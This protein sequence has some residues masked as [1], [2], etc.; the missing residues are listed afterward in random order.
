MLKWC[1]NRRTWLPKWSQISPKIDQKTMRTND[2]K[3][4]SGNLEK[5]ATRGSTN[6]EKSETWG[7]DVVQW[8]FL[9]RASRNVRIPLRLW[10][11]Q[12]LGIDFARLDPRNGGGE[13]NWTMPSGSHRRPFGF[14]AEC[15]MRAFCFWQFLADLG[16]SMADA[17]FWHYFFLRVVARISMLKSWENMKNEVQRFPKCIKNQ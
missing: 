11:L 13:F 15:C 9:G 16:R 14:C 1:E 8:L 10:S 3:Q 7:L 2:R 12:G 6:R 5:S 17:R 4:I